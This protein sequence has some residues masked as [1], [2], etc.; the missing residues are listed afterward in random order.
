MRLRP[1][2]QE[3]LTKQVADWL[4]EHLQP[5]AVGAVIRAE[6]TCMTLRG[7]HATGSTTVGMEVLS[8]NPATYCAGE[9]CDEVCDIDGCPILPSA[10]SRPRHRVLPAVASTQQIGIGRAISGD[11]DRVLP[12][13]QAMRPTA[14]YRYLAAAQA[15]EHTDTGELFDAETSLNAA[16]RP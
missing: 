9:Q 14:T 12:D 11:A 7:V 2:R 13:L 1:Q 5:M 8:G 10:V 15:G 3:R 16:L 4:D 6:H